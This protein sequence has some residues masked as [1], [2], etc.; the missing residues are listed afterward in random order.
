VEV[1]ASADPYLAHQRDPLKREKTILGKGGEPLSCNLSTLLRLI[2][3]WTR[4]PSCGDPFSSQRQGFRVE[5]Q[6]S[7]GYRIPPWN[8]TFSCGVTEATGRV[9]SVG[10]GKLAA[11]LQGAA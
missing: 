8:I 9:V 7:H 5:S 11:K 6:V 1:I 10:T 2:D 4:E 3:S